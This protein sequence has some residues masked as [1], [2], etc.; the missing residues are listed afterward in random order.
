MIINDSRVLFNNGDTPRPA[1]PP[2]IVAD[3]IRTP[4]NIGNLIRLAANIGV[5]RVV[6]I[7]HTPHKESKIRKTACMAWDYVELVHATDDNFAQF[8]PDDYLWTALETSDKSVGIYSAALPQKMAL[9][10][11]N[12]VYGI[13]QELLDRCP[14]HVNIPMCGPATSMNVSHATAVAL[15]EWLRQCGLPK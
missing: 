8:L 14:L 3:L 6:S 7:E 1:T 10:V 2:I 11:G 9:F 4:E 12:E 13:R 15:F 5:Q